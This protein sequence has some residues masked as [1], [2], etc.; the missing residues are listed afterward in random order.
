MRRCFAARFAPLAPRH[1][2]QACVFA[3]PGAILSENSRLF[4]AELLSPGCV[5]NTFQLQRVPFPTPRKEITRLAL[6]LALRFYVFLCLLVFKN[7]FSVFSSSTAAVAEV[8]QTISRNPVF[9]SWGPWQGPCSGAG[10]R[11]VRNA[12][13]GLVFCKSDLNAT[14]WKPEQHLPAKKLLVARDPL[15]KSYRKKVAAKGGSACF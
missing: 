3:V 15:Q 11:F 14:C 4:R 13:K 7:K 5:L 6:Q 12:G 2:A 1:L 8:V 10:E 9:E